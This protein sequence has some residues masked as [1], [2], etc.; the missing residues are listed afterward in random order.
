MVLGVERGWEVR[1]KDRTRIEF[2]K[3]QRFQFG[4]RVVER[5]QGE[6]FE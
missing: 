5:W 2:A 1:G 3:E 4:V 6:R